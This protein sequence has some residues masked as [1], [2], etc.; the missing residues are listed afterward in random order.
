MQN[1]YTLYILQC[2]DGTLYTGITNNLE[3][4]LEMH[5]SGKG[6]KYVRA[7]LPFTLVY[8]ETIEGRS[9]ASKR[10]FEIKQMTKLQKL[11]LINKTKLS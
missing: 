5:N 11:S 10:E 9:L 4:R 2:S 1:L 8:T 7:K 6:S 3:H